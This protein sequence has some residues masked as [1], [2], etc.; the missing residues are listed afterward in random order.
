MK[1]FFGQTIEIG[2]KIAF[3]YPNYHGLTI[4]E[5]VGFTPK[6]VKVEYKYQNYLMTTHT[7]PSQCIKKPIGEQN[8]SS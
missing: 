5:V 7:E 1:D 4:G 6:R 8:E 2:D 3:N